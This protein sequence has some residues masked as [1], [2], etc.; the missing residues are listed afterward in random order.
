MKPTVN[1][2][3]TAISKDVWDLKEGDVFNHP[4]LGQVMFQK[5]RVK[6][7]SAYCF[8]DGKS[9][10]IRMGFGAKVTV[11]GTADLPKATNDYD[12]LRKSPKGTMFVIK[13]GAR[14]AAEMYI[15]EGF[16]SSGKVQ[17]RSPFTNGTVTIAKDFTFK[18]VSSIK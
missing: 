5:M 2:L 16:T 14:D 15:L 1:H 10:S 18:L 17:G 11:I 9:Y 12:L 6:R 13:T 8:S 4:S 7:M 3:P